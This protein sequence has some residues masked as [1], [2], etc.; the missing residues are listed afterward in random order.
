MT[1]PRARSG[2]RCSS[3]FATRRARAR[4][5]RGRRDH[6]HQQPQSRDARDRSRNIG[7]AARGSFRRPSSPS[8]RAACR[9]APTSSASRAAGAD[10]VLVG[11]AISAARGSGRGGRAISPASRGAMERVSAEIKFCGL[12]RAEDA[13]VRRVARRGVRRRD[14]RRRAAAAR[15]STRARRSARRAA[16]GPARGRVRATSR[17]DEI[18]RIAREAG[19]RRRAAARRCRR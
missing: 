5:R 9:A 17:R 1:A 10:A 16:V 7:A 14:L 6:R 12:T 11:S 18:A 15:R 8:P 2:S 3:R 4:A 19:A 13:D